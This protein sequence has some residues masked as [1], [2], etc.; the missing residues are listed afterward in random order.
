MK[1][2]NSESKA[3]RAILEWIDAIKSWKEEKVEGGLNI[4]NKREKKDVDVRIWG[5]VTASI[6]Y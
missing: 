1:D 3:L 6:Q 4:G 2:G 5:Q